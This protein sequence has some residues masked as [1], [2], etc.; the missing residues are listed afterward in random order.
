MTIRARV[1]ASVAGKAGDAWP[2]NRGASG[3]P[4]VPR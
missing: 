2:T 4:A 1:A 3:A